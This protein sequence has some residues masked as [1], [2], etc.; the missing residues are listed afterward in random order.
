MALSSFKKRIAD[1][2][3]GQRASL[4]V[5]AACVSVLLYIGCAEQRRPEPLP[6]LERA[7]F[8]DPAESP[9]VLP[10][11]VGTSYRLAQSYCCPWGG[12]RDQLAYD[13]EM[14][15][16]TD[17][18]A[19]RAGIVRRVRDDLPDAGAEQD[20]GQH[21]HILIQHEDG[22][23]AL[24]GHLQQHGLAVREGDRVESGQRIAASG[25]S[26]NTKGEPHLHFGVYQF[27]PATER[28]DV[29]VNFRNA[30]GPLD[31]RGSLV[32]GSHYEAIPY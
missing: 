11:P 22:T 2:D 21:N 18:T 23:V 5:L 30:R 25:N 26:G 29:P 27:W 8:G 15:I 6:C 31:S 12:H 13:F 17:V 4:V 28:F 1:A 32:A 19:A 10:Y 9:Y 20:P 16:G 7:V 3:L 24:Y 14:P